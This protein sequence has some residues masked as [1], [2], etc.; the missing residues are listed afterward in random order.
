MVVAVKQNGYEI[1]KPTFGR[2]SA[3][4]AFVRTLANMVWAVWRQNGV[5]PMA[6]RV[7]VLRN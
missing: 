6:A 3:C 7:L 5:R 2:L 1:I 4:I